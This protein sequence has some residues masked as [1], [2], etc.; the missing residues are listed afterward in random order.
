MTCGAPPYAENGAIIAYNQ[1]NA[2]YICHDFFEMDGHNT[3]VC[4]NS[5]WE[6]APTCN[7]T[8]ISYI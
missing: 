2:K 6:K 3:I 7:C 4:N 8:C 5:S 1:R